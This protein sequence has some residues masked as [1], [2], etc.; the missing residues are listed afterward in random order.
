MHDW[1][2]AGEDLGRIKVVITEGLAH[3]KG[4]ATVFRRVKN[5]VLFSFQHAPLG[6]S[7]IVTKFI[8]IY[9]D[10][11]PAVLEDA[12]IAW[13]NAGMWHQTTQQIY[14]PSSPSRSGATDPDAHAH[15]PRRRRAFREPNQDAPI[16]IAPVKLLSQASM[17]PPTLRNAMAGNSNWTTVPL[18]QDLCFEGY[19]QQV[20]R[21][22]ATRVS[23]SDQ[24]MPDYSHSITP[25]SSRDPS[26]QTMQ[27]DGTATQHESQFEELMAAF[28]PAKAS[29]TQAPP[30]TRVSSATN[31]PL[32]TLK[33]VSDAEVRITSYHG[34]PRAVSM[35]TREVPPSSARV[36]TDVSMKSRISESQAE[37]KE[38]AHPK[39][40]VA[41][42]TEIK[43]R[44]EGK[45]SEV[46]PSK[47]VGE[48]RISTG[49]NERRVKDTTHQ[50]EDHDAS[51]NECKR[52]RASM[53]SIMNV[54]AENSEGPDSSPSRKVSKKGRKDGLDNPADSSKSPES[55]M[56]APLGTLQNIQ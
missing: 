51:A 33:P 13:P 38:K 20:P 43:G 12:G 53:T 25:R 46:N 26:L 14:T 36:P 19:R 37:E 28:S 8:L 31:S 35:T 44:K 47:L 27:I 16:A 9:A 49:S 2:S 17:P 32:K 54:L 1:W 29:G 23:T 39:I 24:S 56:R 42:A 34:Q 40:K 5:V 22:F 50:N 18:M 30:T 21:R 48:K 10:M 55:T 6:K 3:G 15:S 11:I 7:L 52:K 45:S 41:P 4:Q